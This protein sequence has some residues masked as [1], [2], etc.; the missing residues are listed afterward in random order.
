[1]SRSVYETEIN[2]AFLRL[3]DQIE[4]LIHEVNANERR[5]RDITLVVEAQRSLTDTLNGLID[6]IVAS[7]LALLLR[8]RESGLQVGLLEQTAIELR[9]CVSRERRIEIVTFIVDTIRMILHQEFLEAQQAIDRAASY[10]DGDDER[11]EERGIYYDEAT[12][13]YGNPT[14]EW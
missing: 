1:M 4:S 5:N 12:T 3:I 11:S 2:A 10:Q 9:I 14:Y 8:A 7:T 13:Y 6:V